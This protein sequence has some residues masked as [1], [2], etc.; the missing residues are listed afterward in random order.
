MTPAE[1][2][3][4]KIVD[5]GPSLRERLRDRLDR[6]AELTC[7]EHGRPVAAVT[8]YARENGWF[9]STWET[10]CEALEQKAAAIVKERC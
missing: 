6:A 4:I 3:R 1:T 8:I 2:M 9:E 10:C 5:R 7:L